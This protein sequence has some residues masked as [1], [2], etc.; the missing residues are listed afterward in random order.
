MDVLF[1]LSSK[2]DPECPD[3]DRSHLSY[4]L[5]D[6]FIS[7]CSHTSIKDM[8]ETL[9]CG[10]KDGE[11]IIILCVGKK[12][13]MFFE[14]NTRSLGDLISIHDMISESFIEEVKNATNSILYAKKVGVSA[15]RSITKR[16][17]IYIDMKTDMKSD[18]IF[19]YM[20]PQLI[21]NKDNG[22]E[23]HIAGFDVYHSTREVESS[24]RLSR[25]LSAPQ[26]VS[27]NKRASTIDGIMQSIS[28]RMSSTSEPNA[29]NR[30][31]SLFELM[32]G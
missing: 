18:V 32:F 28:G 21:V 7:E 29:Q 31:K 3:I 11:K 9:V 8:C 16:L 25:I 6:T 30:R 17:R 19:N 26:Q 13:Y 22:I 10:C 15:K 2:K 14:E 4:K 24:K 27:V 23:T 5:I 1:N 20:I 12:D